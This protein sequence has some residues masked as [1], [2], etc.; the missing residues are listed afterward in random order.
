MKRIVQACGR[1]SMRLFA[2]VSSGWS[3]VAENVAE[4]QM[5]EVK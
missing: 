5:R 3:T 4:G 2:S 1:E